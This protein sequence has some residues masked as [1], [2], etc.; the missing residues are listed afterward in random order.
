[1]FSAGKKKMQKVNILTRR[2]V[3]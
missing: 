3:W 1:M 2:D